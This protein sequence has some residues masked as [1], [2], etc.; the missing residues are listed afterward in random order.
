MTHPTRPRRRL[1]AA[2]DPRGTTGK[3]VG[4]HDLRHTFATYLVA[5]GTDVKTAGSPM[6]H[7]NAMMTPDVYASADP[8]A[9]LFS[10]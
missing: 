7:A 5:K 4:Q 8:D 1:L 6:G 10:R 3:R 9:R 2:L